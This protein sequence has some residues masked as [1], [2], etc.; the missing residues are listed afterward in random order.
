LIVPAWF[1]V[2][3]MELLEVDVEGCVNPAA[4][5]SLLHDVVINVGYAHWITLHLLVVLLL[6]TTEVAFVVLFCVTLL[7]SADDIVAMPVDCN[8]IW[9]TE[10]VWLFFGL[11]AFWFNMIVPV[12]V[13][14]DSVES[15]NSVILVLF[16]FKLLK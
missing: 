1:A 7:L 10:W 6:S 2:V 3:D 15:G 8:D 5:C 11:S 16:I 13:A 12:D 4:C 14:D 9:L